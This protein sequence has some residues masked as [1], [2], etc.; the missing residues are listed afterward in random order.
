MDSKRKSL[1]SSISTSRPKTTNKIFKSFSN[2]FEDIYERPKVDTKRSLKL[3]IAIKS[4][5][6][7]TGRRDLWDKINMV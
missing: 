7:E 4:K 6:G 1:P 3:K 2:Q 5:R